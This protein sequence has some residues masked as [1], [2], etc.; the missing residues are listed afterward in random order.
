GWEAP[1]AKPRKERGPAP[2]RERRCFHLSPRARGL[3]R[4]PLHSPEDVR[5]NVLELGCFGVAGAARM[6][7]V[8]DRDAE[9]GEQ[10]RV[11]H[12]RECTT[13]PTLRVLSRIWE[14]L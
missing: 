3:R 7:P 14:G 2:V 8:V 6:A 1:A 13:A 5:L 9:I 10:L 12:A 4:E 11:D